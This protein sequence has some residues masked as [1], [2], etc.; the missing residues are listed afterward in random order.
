M[1]NLTTDELR[2][3]LYEAQEHLR[4]AIRLI[5]TYVNAT[6]DRNAEAYLLDHLRIFAGREHGFL[7]RDLNIDDLMQRLD[8]RDDE[9]DDEA[10]DDAFFYTPVGRR[11]AALLGDDAVDAAEPTLHTSTGDRLYWCNSIQG[12]VTV[13]TDED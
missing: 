13:P 11:I 12:Y 10:D 5:E 7:T 1:T 9:T 2:D 4:A 3:A 6:D 8:E